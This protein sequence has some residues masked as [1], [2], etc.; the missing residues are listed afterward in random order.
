MRPASPSPRSATSAFTLLEVIL[1]LAIAAVV[2]VAV[3][4][5]FYS[6]LK[7]RQRSI[8]AIEA[9]QP[10]Q[11]TLAIIERDLANLVPPGGTFSGVLQ[12]SPTNLSVRPGLASP[13]FHTATGVVDDYRPW[14]E[15]QKV[16]YLL[17]QSTSTNRGSGSTLVRSVVRNL[18]PAAMDEYEDEWLMD[19]VESLTFSFYDG[20]QWWP[21]WD[22]TSQ[23][24]SFP[25]AIKVD[26]QPAAATRTSELPDPVELIIPLIVEASTNQT[27]QASSGSANAGGAP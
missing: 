25:L 18:L 7:L 3:N 14:A 4:S 5:L 26:L 13:E 8:E 16:S 1:A 10:L 15:I 11:R 6:A 22:S 23:T 9:T 17:T 24:P 19:G 20:T 27:S 2:L 12:T 21:T